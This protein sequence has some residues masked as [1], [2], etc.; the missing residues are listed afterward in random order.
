[1]A[2]VPASSRFGSSGLQAATVTLTNAQIAA[3]GTANA[4]RG[5]ELVAAPDAG[6]VLWCRGVLLTAHTVVAYTFTDDA[7]PGLDASYADGDG[8]VNTATTQLAG[9]GTAVLLAR[10][11][12]GDDSYALLEPYAAAPDASSYGS[13]TA[14]AL[15]TNAVGLAGPITGGDPANTFTW[16][17]LYTVESV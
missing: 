14:A 8:I 2:G 3:I 10:T 5:Y 13:V 12:T 1:M 6:N 17:V 4:G 16:H 15:R 11:G 9:A 7:A